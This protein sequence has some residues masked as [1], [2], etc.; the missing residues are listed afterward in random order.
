MAQRTQRKSR[1]SIPKRSRT[2]PLKGNPDEGDGIDDG[3]YYRCWHCGF[4]CDIDK[5]ALGGPESKSGKILEDYSPASYGGIATLDGLVEHFHIAARNGSDDTP[6]TALHY[7]KTSSSST[8][9]PQCH[10]KNW[11]GDYP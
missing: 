9:C 5:D 6:L 11:R 8:G 3:K 7:F 10:T 2:I 4:I 1:K